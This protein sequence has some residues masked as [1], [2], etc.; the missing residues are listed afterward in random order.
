MPTGS[1]MVPCLLGCLLYTLHTF[2][3]CVTSV[4]GGDIICDTSIFP[5]DILLSARQ[6]A[7][8]RLYHD[9]CTYF[10]LQSTMFKF[11]QDVYNYKTRQ[12][13]QTHTSMASSEFRPHSIRMNGAII[14]NYFNTRL[15]MIITY[16][17]MN[18]KCILKKNIVLQC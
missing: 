11:N 12:S 16:S 18:Y 7:L 17:L 10:N 9:L 14:R 13:S 6:E 4:T 2:S 5:F 1:E 3:S 8:S 15:N